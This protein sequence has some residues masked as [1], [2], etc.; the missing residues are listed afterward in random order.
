PGCVELGDF[1]ATST[2]IAYFPCR[3]WRNVPQDAL[4]RTFDKFYEFFQQRRGSDEWDRYTPYELRLMQTYV[5]RGEIDRAHQLADFYF[6]HQRPQ[7]W[8][9]WA[10]VVFREPRAAGFIGDMPHTWV[11][12]AYM[13][14]LRSM[15]V[16]EDTNALI[17]AAG[18]PAAWYGSGEPIG[19]RNAPTYFG[20]LTYSV[21]SDN[22]G[23][24]LNIDIPPDGGAQTIVLKIHDDDFYV[25]KDDANLLISLDKNIMT[26]RPGVGE[27]LL[28]R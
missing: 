2:A 11:G 9:H 3:Q 22:E 14:A 21:V 24:T 8:N 25:L 20:T 18:I 28:G 15:L 4:S 12:S 13:N 26:L 7:G 16:Y 1:D 5:V 17:L 10:E 27:V 23:L 19:I 6:S